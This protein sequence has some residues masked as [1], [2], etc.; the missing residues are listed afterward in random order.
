M[1]GS[2]PALFK[3]ANR[4][5]FRKSFLWAVVIAFGLVLSTG[6][7]LRSSPQQSLTGELDGATAVLGGAI[8]AFGTIIPGISSS[9]ILMYLGVYERLLALLPGLIYNYFPH[10]GRVRDHARPLSWWS[11]FQ[12]YRVLLIMVT[13]FLLVDRNNL[14]TGRSSVILDLM[15]LMAIAA[16]FCLDAFKPNRH[17]AN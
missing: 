12:R 16:L 3:E 4:R 8:L 14:S 5:G 17:A 7:L 11:P 2:I 13:G 10:G 9:L 6:S 1:A 15:L